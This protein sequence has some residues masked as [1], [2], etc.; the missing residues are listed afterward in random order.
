MYVLSYLI[1]FLIICLLIL[2]KGFKFPIQLVNF[3]FYVYLALL[4][5]NFWLAQGMFVEYSLNPVDMSNTSLYLQFVFLINAFVAFILPLKSNIIIFAKDSRSNFKFQATGKFYLFVV[6]IIVLAFCNLLITKNIDNSV[7][8]VLYQCTDFAI[9]LFGVLL[10][11]NKWKR[12]WFLVLLYSSFSIYTGFR[13]KI[14][15]IFIT[16]ISYYIAKSNLLASGK[17]TLFSLVKVRYLLLLPILPLFAVFLSAMTNTRTKVT[18]DIF[19]NLSVALNSAISDNFS[20]LFSYSFFAESN[21]INPLILV[22]KDST[23]F[24]VNFP[25]FLDSLISHICVLL[26]SS[27]RFEYDYLL[28]N[29]EILGLFGTKQ[30]LSSGTS[31]PYIAYLNLIFNSF[32]SI[33]VYTAILYVVLININKFVYFCFTRSNDCSCTFYRNGFSTTYVD[34][35]AFF[36]FSISLTLIILYLF[37]FRGFSPEIFKYMLLFMFSLYFSIKGFKL[38]I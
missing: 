8:K 32:A 23:D 1:T 25:F 36:T 33:I 31:Y 30:A 10:L 27:L 19:T 20:L 26:P 21:V 34:A 24:F 18:G 13:Y 4:A 14:F 2:S 17:L 5:P 7:S 16:F 11:S 9:P 12:L 28:L 3:I 37:M 15:F 29:N 22:L 6:S 35:H 38:K